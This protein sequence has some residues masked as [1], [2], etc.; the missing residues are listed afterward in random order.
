MNKRKTGAVYEEKAAAYLKE[1][2]YRILE[3]NYRCPLGEIDL[4]AKDG[5][6]LVFVEVKYRKNARN[7]YP[8]EAVDTRKQKKICETAAYYVYKNR[9]PEYTPMRF[10]VV[11]VLDGEFKLIKD[12]FYERRGRE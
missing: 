6:T 1:K 9:I 2:G 4:I 11:A 3:K 10:D 5:R 8:E 7:G 12:A